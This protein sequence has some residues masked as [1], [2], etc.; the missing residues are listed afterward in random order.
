MQAIEQDE[1]RRCTMPDGI[2]KAFGEA[3]SP[4][5]GTFYGK[6]MAIA[7]LAERI[8]FLDRGQGR[9]GVKLREMLARLRSDQ[10]HADLSEMLRSHEAD[11]AVANDVAGHAS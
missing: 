2:I 4:E 3:S 8:T 7:D 10:R 6:A 9:G 5:I 1:A 11:I